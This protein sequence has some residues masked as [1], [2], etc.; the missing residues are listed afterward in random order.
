MTEGGE[1][2]GGHGNQYE[3]KK[4]RLESGNAEAIGICRSE[5]HRE[6][7]YIAKEF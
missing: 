1:T 6:G 3:W 5:N 2:Q 4:R 7:S